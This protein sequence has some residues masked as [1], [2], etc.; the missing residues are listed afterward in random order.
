MAAAVADF[1]PAA[2]RE[3]KIKKA[4]QSGISLELEATTDVLAGL[5][6]AAPPRPDAR[7]LRR[8]ARR[9]A[10]SSSARASSCRRVSTRS[11]STTSRVATSAS[12]RT[13]TRSRSS[14]P[15]ATATARMPRRSRS[16]RA[17]KSQ[18]AEADP[19]RRLEA[20]RRS[21]KWRRMES[22]YDLYQ[23]GNELL[24]HGDYQAAIVPLSKAR[25][26][27]PE[28]AS[29]REALGRA[30]FHAQR[31]EGA[32]A[33]FEAVVAEHADE[34]L[35]AVLPGPLDAAAR[36][37]SRGAPAA[38]AGLLAAPRA[39]GLPQVPRPRAARRGTLLERHAGPRSGRRDRAPCRESC[40]AR[41]ARCY[42][43]SRTFEPARGRRLQHRKWAHARFFCVKEQFDD[44]HS[45]GYRATTRAQR[46]RRRGAARRGSRRR[47][48][49]A[50]SS[51]I[52]TASRSSCASA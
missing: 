38:G 13:T 20:A 25:D 45:G 50:C 8:R 30:L 21:L 11:S 2:P 1:R 19:R 33:E 24:D 28:K 31:Y 49:C 32:A 7:R 46:A 14:R 22:V 27:E 39:R 47:A 16:R 41:A 3:D 36:A 15:A 35:R 37:P 34:R 6:R 44:T 29:I 40:S 52:P 43:R 9:R 42:A 5:V 48:R 17:P 18:V 26:L 4:G 23:R 10:R 51:T 12:T